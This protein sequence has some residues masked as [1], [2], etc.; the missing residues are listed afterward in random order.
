MVWSNIALV[1]LNVS[2]DGTIY[3]VWIFS[4][5]ALQKPS[6][7]TG[8]P[9]L[10][11]AGTPGWVCGSFSGGFCS[12]GGMDWGLRWEVGR[13]YS[14][15]GTLK[16]GPVVNKQKLLPKFYNMNLGNSKYSIPNIYVL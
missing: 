10:F 2:S 13:P 3:F 12:T 14:A 8:R 11:S 15:A 16:E 6:H 7:A 1:S 9:S 5:F 4:L